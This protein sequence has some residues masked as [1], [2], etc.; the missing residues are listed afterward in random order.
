[1]KRRLPLPSFLRSGTTDAELQYVTSSDNSGPAFQ[2]RAVLLCSEE[3]DDGDNAKDDETDQNPADRLTNPRGHAFEEPL[4]QPRSAAFT[5]MTLHH[6]LLLGPGL[7]PMVERFLRLD[8]GRSKLGHASY[9][10]PLAEADLSL[11]HP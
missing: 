1:M 3:G 7:A 10:F 6:C 9:L 4:P 11:K 2:V 8:V 5:A